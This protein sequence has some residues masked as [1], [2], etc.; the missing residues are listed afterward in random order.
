MKPYLFA[1]ATAAAAQH[2]PRIAAVGDSITEG[3]CS[4]DESKYSWPVKLA[5]MLTRGDGTSDYEV[6]NFGVSGRTSLRKGDF[7]YWVEPKYQEAKDYQPQIV[8][9]MFGTN[10]SNL[11]VESG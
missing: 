4:S 10:D 5:N 3:A 7:P 9:I 6:K 1:I 11:P 8:I 2:K